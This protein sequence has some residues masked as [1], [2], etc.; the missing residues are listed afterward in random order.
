MLNKRS[1][2]RL[3]QRLHQDQKLDVIV[4]DEM[5]DEKQKIKDVAKLFLANGLANPLDMELLKL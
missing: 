4:K 1:T 3:P 5:K 2:R